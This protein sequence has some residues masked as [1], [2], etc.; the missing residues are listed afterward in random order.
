MIHW[1]LRRLLRDTFS[2]ISKFLPFCSSGEL[3]RR[4]NSHSKEARLHA[5]REREL[6]YFSRRV[7][8]WGWWGGLASGRFSTRQWSVVSP[9]PRWALAALTSFK[10]RHEETCL[11]SVQW[12]LNFFLFTYLVNIY[13]RVTTP[14]SFSEVVR[15]VQLSETFLFLFFFFRWTSVSWVAGTPRAAQ[16]LPVWCQRWGAQLQEATVRQWQPGGRKGQPSRVVSWGC[17]RG[18]WYL[19][20]FRGISVT[21]GTGQTEP[22]H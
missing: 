5:F 2:V 1:I 18:G 14:G 10:W 21:Q 16:T 15:C 11:S 17:R 22:K 12:L 13:S 6:A 20:L 7:E 19:W 4:W 9:E 8:W 3:W